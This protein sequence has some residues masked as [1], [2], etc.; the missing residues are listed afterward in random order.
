MNQIVRDAL[1]RFR[2]SGGFACSVLDDEAIE[3]LLTLAN[4]VDREHPGEED[5]GMVVCVRDRGQ[6]VLIQG[7]NPSKMFT[8]DRVAIASN[9]EEIAAMMRQD[10]FED[11]G[12]YIEISAPMEWS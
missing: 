9:L 10:K 4:Q 2:N 1:E 5:L 11:D 3:D 6:L 12:S 7:W 8:T